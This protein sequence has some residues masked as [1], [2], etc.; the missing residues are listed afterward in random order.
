[1][2]Y[3]EGNQ[4]WKLRSKHGRSKL[5]ESPELLWDAAC[6]YFQSVDENPFESVEKKTSGLYDEEV[7][8]KYH[9]RPYLISA[10]CLY[11]GASEKYLAD[12]KGRLIEE[13][14]PE[15][16]DFLTVI[17]QIYETVRSQKFEGA[18]AGLFNSNIIARDL[19][20][21]EHTD[22]TSDGN[23]IK[24]VNV[25]VVSQDANNELNKMISEND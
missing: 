5:F 14:K 13:K 15:N 16:D 4:L 8:T 19:G 6:E 1:M 11:V 23:E 18:A 10:F 24:G 20:L 2:G 9:K 7:K 21:K 25:T 3:K 22:H 12:F 17:N